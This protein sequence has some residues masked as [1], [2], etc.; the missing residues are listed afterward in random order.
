M[1]S[2]K[3][4]RIS[5]TKDSNCLCVF[6]AL[7][8]KSMMNNSN[9][10]NIFFQLNFF[11]R[12]MKLLKGEDQIRDLFSNIVELKF[13]YSSKLSKF[14]KFFELFESLNV[15]NRPEVKST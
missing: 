8:I 6:A 2:Q 10:M 7:L 15:F 13:V 5:I 4:N 14:I 11:Y 9:F 1:T 3:V 12:S